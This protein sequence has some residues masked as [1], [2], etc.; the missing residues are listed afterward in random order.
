MITELDFRAVQA[1][2]GTDGR[3]A[4]MAQELWPLLEEW[5]G[6]ESRTRAGAAADRELFARHMP[7]LLPVLDR[8]AGQLDRA[9]GAELL[10][11]VGLK[12]FF[13]NCSQTGVDGVLLRNYDFDPRYCGRV[14]L[15]S[16][17]LRPVIGMSEILWGLLD[18]MNDAGLAVSLTFGGR[19]VHGRGFSIMMVIRYLLETCETV[20]EA[21][22]T[23]ERLPIATAQN[24]TLVDGTESRTV[25]VG[26]D[27][28]VTPTDEVCTTNHQ[29][30]PVPEAT[31]VFTETGARLAAIRAAGEQD[32][33]RVTAVLEAL[34]RPPLY[35]VH[36]DQ[37][38][39]TIYT[40]AY[41][42]AEGT[43]SYLWPEDRW[44]QSFEKFEPGTRTVT[45]G[46]VREQA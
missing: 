12:P 20:D 37:G 45:A 39:G 19:M 8:L 14:V 41:R 29:H 28:P 34:L 43:V 5:V 44:D 31:E 7:E 11:Q 42:P 10:A 36:Y 30:A 15:S 24:L 16:N 6:E 27:I 25:H 18:G 23:L 21:V 3:W 33:D 13:A 46:G 9:G 35:R 38:F 22:R 1:G 40:A 26:P 4:E 32:G 2:E 17:F